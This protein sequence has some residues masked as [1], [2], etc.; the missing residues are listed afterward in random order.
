MKSRQQG[1]IAAREQA[2]IAEWQP[3]ST[4]RVPGELVQLPSSLPS[5]L[6][7]QSGSGYEAIGHWDCC[8]IIWLRYTMCVDGPSPL[9]LCYSRPSERRRST[10]LQEVPRAPSVLL[11][12][13]L[14]LLRVS[15]C[16][17]CAILR[18][19]NIPYKEINHGKKETDTTVDWNE[20]H[21]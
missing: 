21:Y 16:G 14:D 13:F 17:K 19:A 20:A 15:Y 6:F 3:G 1:R 5:S 11:R 12:L 10:S 4:A 9:I 2:I 18:S 8:H 7:R